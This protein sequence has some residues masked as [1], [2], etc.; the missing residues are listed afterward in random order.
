MYP[1]AQVLV[2]VVTHAPPALPEQS[3]SWLV[4]PDGIA[5]QI[6][7]SPVNRLAGPRRKG[8]SSHTRVL[9]TDVATSIEAGPAMKS[10]RR[11]PVQ[12]PIAAMKP[13]NS[14]SAMATVWAAAG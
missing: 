1:G 11:R 8:A 14:A 5:N 9:S 10:L 13:A 7:D 2:E 6:G 12:P 4:S 3:G